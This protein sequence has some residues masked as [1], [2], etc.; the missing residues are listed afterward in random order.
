MTRSEPRQKSQRRTPKR[1]A[2]R[3]TPIRNGMLLLL[4]LFLLSFLVVVLPK[5]PGESAAR[6]FV[7]GTENGEEGLSWAQALQINEVMTS[8]GSSF[9]DDTGNYPDWIEIANI[10]EIPVSLEGIGLSDREDRV[11]FIFPNVELEAGGY[12]V[13]FCDDTNQSEAGKTW[14]ARFKLSALGETVFLLNPDA[15]IFD[16]VQ[17]PALTS[18]ISYAKQAGEWVMTE[19]ATPGYPNTL[20][21]YA[22]MRESVRGHADG[23]VINELQASNLSTITDEDGDYS[24]WIELYNGGTLPIDLSYYAITDD[25]TKPLKLRFP[26]GA[27]IAPG[28]YY[29]LFASGKN[30]PGGPVTDGG[31]NHPHTNFKLGAERETVTLCDIYR[32][33]IDKVAYENLGADTSW[34]RIP[35][36]GSQFQ[37]YQAPT[38]GLPNTRQSEIE[39]D[40]RMRANNH[41]GV[42]ISEA[43]TNSTGIETQYGKTS[44]DWIEITNLGASPVNLKNWGLSDSVNYPRKWQFGDVEIIPGEHLL[45]FASGLSQSPTRSGALHSNFRLSAVGE[46]ISLCDPTGKIIDKLVVPKLETNN[47]YGRDFGQGGLFYFDQPTAGDPNLTQ[48]FYGYAPAPAINQKGAL[49]TRP[50]T[51]T[52]SAPEGVRVRYTL[53]GSFPTETNGEDYTGEIEIKRAAVLRARGFVDGL[54][55]SDTVTESF[56]INAYHELPVISLTVDP[57]DLW[58][59]VSGIYA[60]GIEIPE[61]YTVEKLLK[62]AVYTN[63]KKNRAIRERHGNI[64][65]FLPEGEQ[66][67]NIGVAAQLHGQYSLALAQKSFR[68]SAKAKYGASMIP[69][70]FFPDR[71]FPEYQAVI[72]RN[73]GNDGAYSRLVDSLAAKMVDWTDSKIIRMASTPVIVYL[74]AQYWG[75]YDVRE[76][77]NTRSIAAYENWPDHTNI[78]LIKGDNNVLNGSFTN[79][80]DLLKFVREKDLNSPANLQYVLDRIDVDSYFD[81]MIFEMYFGNTDTLNIKFYRQRVSGAKWKWLFFDLDWA[82][83]NRQRDGCFV[84]LDPK[85]S[86]DKNAENILIRKLLAVPEMRDK[87][88][89]RYGELFQILSDTSRVIAL[90]DEMRDTI[91]PEMG[92]HFNRWA[93]ETFK[94]VAFDP[95]SEPEAAYNYWLGRVNRLKNVARA[96]P[97]Y[98]WG[99]VQ[100]WFELSDAQMEGYFGTR[101]E[102]TEDIY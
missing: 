21:A 5:T 10:S 38:P 11:S 9:P 102:E 97:Y 34:G 70:A 48:G 17:V 32:Q 18:D 47:S 36:T 84:W 90:I 7:P 6:S 82:Y 29:L 64:E 4:L 3:G 68:I 45:V 56:L 22:E 59:P 98:V 28:E 51:V 39:M 69:F 65:Y 71:P 25:E 35:G 24:D 92:M 44:Y 19:Y 87:F 93:G 26:S 80:S 100:D 46:T 83:F 33:V 67:F 31:L 77:Q 99:H 61:D 50:T 16:S 88:L 89:K 75:H 20:E 73:G 27:V 49:L 57:D 37:V 72:L 60:L 101:P 96:R 66:I 55:P 12:A 40:T 53:D 95:P 8:N 2:R 54:K 74:N 78:D 94:F 52:I 79:Y 14:H 62:N 23:L 86:G 58:N 15:Q 76:R 42:F 41:T 85:G 63:V 1:P 13:V 81:F 43:V 91:E 30:R